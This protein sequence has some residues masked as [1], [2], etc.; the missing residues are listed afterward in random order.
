[1]KSS[2]QLGEEGI[3]VEEGLDP[4]LMSNMLRIALNSIVSDMDPNESNQ[5]PVG[6]SLPTAKKVLHWAPNQRQEG[7]RLIHGGNTP[8]PSRW[9]C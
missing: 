6:Q 5:A 7:W 9:N 3:E 1:M 4:S 2:A 8:K